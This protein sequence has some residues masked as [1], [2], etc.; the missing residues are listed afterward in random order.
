[1]LERLFANISPPKFGKIFGQRRPKSLRRDT[2]NRCFLISCGNVGDL[3]VCPTF[4]KTGIYT[5]SKRCVILRGPFICRRIWWQLNGCLNR[6]RLCNTWCSATIFSSQCN[7]DSAIL[8][9]NL[10]KF[11]QIGFCTVRKYPK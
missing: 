10:S 3:F 4:H 7:V 9:K 1:M 6:Q 2:F 11:G 8:I 5:C